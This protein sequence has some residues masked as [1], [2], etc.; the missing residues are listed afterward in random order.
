VSIRKDLPAIVN[1]ILQ[2]MRRDIQ[3]C[4]IHGIFVAS[5]GLGALCIQDVIDLVFDSPEFGLGIGLSYPANQGK[6]RIQRTSASPL[7]SGR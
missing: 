2:T 4:S 6:Q 3:G 7:D 5:R 1:Q